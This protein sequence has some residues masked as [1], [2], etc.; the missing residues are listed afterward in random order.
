MAAVQISAFRA[1]RATRRPWCAIVHLLLC[2]IAALMLVTPARA[3]T[4][5]YMNDTFSYDTPSAS[6]QTVAWHTSSAAPACTSFPNGD[7]DWF[8]LT[9]STATTPA[10]TFTFTFGGVVY[11]QV[12]IYSN[13]SLAFNDTS[14]YWRDYTNTTLPITTASGM[15]VSGCT[16]AAPARFMSV[17]WLDIVA[18]TANST[19]GA[20][21][22]YEL[23]GTAPNRRLVISW[24]NVKLYNQTARYNFQ[25]ALYESPGG[26]INSNFKFQYT[27]GSATGTGATV[28]V[29]LTTSD[30]TLYSYNQAFIDPTTGSAILWYPANQSVAKGAEYRFDEGTWNG[31]AGEVKDTS[32]GSSHGVKVGAA[33]STSNGKIC[34]GGDFTGNNSTTTI[35]GVSIPITPANVGSV[36]LWYKSNSAWTANDAM[37]IDATSVAT[38]PFFFMRTSSGTLKFSVSD[39]AGTVLTATSAAQSFAAST[40]HHVGVS[41]NL[42]PGTNQSLL[43]IFLDGVLLTTARGTTTGSI[44][45]LSTLL[46]GDNRTSGITPSGSGT[47]QA[48]NA[49]LDE[50][51]VYATQI[52]ANQAATDMNATRSGCTSVDHFHVVHGGTS[53]TCDIAPV[54]IE[55]H[56]S[57]HALI[58]LSGVTMSLSTSTNRGNWSNSTGGAI[59]SIN[60][61]GSGAATYVFS[62]ESSVTFGL[63]DLTV[64]SLTIGAAAGTISTTSGAA[65]TCAAADY[66]F[67]S[68]C[69][70]ALSFVA[71]GLRFVNAAGTAIGNHVAGTNAGTYYLQAVRQSTNSSACVSLFPANTSVNINLAYECNNP[72]TCQVG[73][74]FTFTPGAGAGSA[75]TIASNANGAVSASSGSYTTRALTFNATSPA[76]LPAVPFTFNYTDVG[77]VRLWAT[78]TPSSGT[79]IAGNA[80]FVV[81]PS[82]FAFS[83][84]SAGPLRAGSAFGATVTAVN[85]A[86]AATPNFGKETS[87][88]SVAISFNRCQP[89]GAG[90]A[91]GAMNGNGGPFTFTG[92]TTTLSALTW[93]EVGRIDLTATLASGSYLGTGLTA[94][95]NTGTAGTLCNGNGNVGAFIPHHFDTQVIAQ[96]CGTFTYSGQPFTLKVT[97]R[98]GLSSPTTT[99]NYDG[100]AATTPN[101]ARAITLSDT[102]GASGALSPSTAPAS[103]FVAGVA[104]L[105]T[106]AWTFA[107]P[108]TKPATIVLRAVDADGT[109]SSGYESAASAPIRSGRLALSNAFGSEKSPLTMNLQTQFWNGAWVTNASDSCTVVPVSAVALSGYTGTLSLASFG[110]TPVS[111]VA[112]PVSYCDASNN[113]KAI[114]GVSYLKLAKPQPNTGSVSVAIDLGAS[115]VD[116]SCLSTH[117]GS[118]AALPWLRGRFG[119][120]AAATSNTADPSARASFGIYTPETRKLIHQRE[121]F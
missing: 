108:L 64:E 95:G 11:N 86:G 79:T 92:G 110:A 82:A 71:A 28:G 87:A 16:D 26:S 4:Y 6:A 41:W 20:S 94:T 42:R 52:N 119:S 101:F 29:Q 121:L 47:A 98:N 97:A 8:D 91:S 103:S 58:S 9:F 50:V 68:T 40:W 75:G 99:V 88:E 85:A 54:T 34:R 18:G 100:S 13:G 80:Q 106:P 3:A 2:A 45:A 77:R 90:A 65:S 69:N 1:I 63:Q 32:G 70:T 53:V 59:N 39:A 89:S 112:S 36:D 109:S 107:T 49:V 66:T 67:G 31:T 61:L 115:G 62:N 93:S 38:R 51:N 81:A 7:D 113:L 35:D 96:G 37:L 117:G 43:Q 30:Y 21:I 83:G 120:C 25:V 102:S 10:N 56:D 60:N 78:Y 73:Q 114:G 76:P 24:V 44:A 22:K 5:A 48:A 104:T 105:S 17:Y 46:V 19:S 55:A 84:V 14:G 12:R 111:C 15:T 33:S 116:Q 27:T 57:A 118:P 23:L 72:T 74:T